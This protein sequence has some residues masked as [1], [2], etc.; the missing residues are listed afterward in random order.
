MKKTLLLLVA[1]VVTATINAQ[2]V[3]EAFD[4]GTFTYEI[5]STDVGGGEPDECAIT[6]WVTLPAA[7]LDLVIPGTATYTGLFPIDY[8]VTS[9]GNG[10][11]SSNT[12]AN[13]GAGFT[14]NTN[15]TNVTL[16]ASVTVIGQHAFRDNANLLS[17]NFENI[18]ETGSN[19]F[20]K[21]NGL[22]GEIDLPVCTT[23][24]GYTFFDCNNITAVNTPVLEDLLVGNYY[25][26]DSVQEYNV[27][28]TVAQVGNL[29]FGQN[30]GLVQVQLNWDATQLAAV[31]HANDSKFFRGEWANHPTN[32]NEPGSGADTSGFAGNYGAMTV[33]ELSGIFEG[34]TKT[35]YVPVGTKTD[36][37]AHLSWCR[38]MPANIVE[39][40]MPALSTRK[41]EQ[42]LSFS[43]Y[44]NPV[45]D[46]VTI[47]N[48]QLKSAAATVYDLNGRA[49]LSRSLDTLVSEINVSNLTSGIYLVKVETENTKF[50]KRIVKQ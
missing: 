7:P 40:T 3:G 30:A 32:P 8:T 23:M 45:S 13:K 21:C 16:P 19:S 48:S 6:G 5:T 49:L 34:S 17:I 47:R 25:N 1:L 28:A 29:C 31:A 9:V 26:N 38:F 15:I 42:D 20:V 43:V 11:F 36:Y 39:G 41:F 44:P 18:V 12:A 50:V 46:V 2:A 37:L 27:P 22:T 14:E 33:T 10:A 4:D 24:G 35:I